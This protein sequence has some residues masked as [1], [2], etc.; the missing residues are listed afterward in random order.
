MHASGKEIVF[1]GGGMAKNV[2]RLKK[3]LSKK[4]GAHAPGTYGTARGWEG[5]AMRGEMHST[6]RLGEIVNFHFFRGSFLFWNS[7]R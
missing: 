3:P 6:A 1:G 4:C 2:L 5:N 7:Y